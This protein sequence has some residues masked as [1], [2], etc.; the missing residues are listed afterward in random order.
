MISITTRFTEFLENGKEKEHPIIFTHAQARVA[1]AILALDY[2]ATDRVIILSLL[3][4]AH[5]ERKNQR[6]ILMFKTT[7]PSNGSTTIL[8]N[9]YQDDMQPL[10]STTLHFLNTSKLSPELQGAIPN[11]ERAK[12]AIA[13]LRGIRDPQELQQARKCAIYDLLNMLYVSIKRN[14]L[15]IAALRKALITHHNNRPKKWI[16]KTNE[17]TL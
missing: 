10:L 17:T 6:V 1:L 2:L 5:S 8:F 3:C 15:T 11:R 9:G 16:I 12:I 14:S 13:M 4:P 7:N